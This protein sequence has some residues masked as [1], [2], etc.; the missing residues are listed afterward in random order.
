MPTRGRPLTRKTVRSMS[1]RFCVPSD[2][3]MRKAARLGAISA[4]RPAARTGYACEA[5]SV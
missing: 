4:Q 3:R 1:R 5:L 2:Q